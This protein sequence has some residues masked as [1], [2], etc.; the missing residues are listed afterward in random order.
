M[1]RLNV[2]IFLATK[3]PLHPY[4][5]SYFKYDFCWFL[6]IAP[7]TCFVKIVGGIY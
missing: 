6:A 7:T 3:R 5:L 1:R 4:L 2:T